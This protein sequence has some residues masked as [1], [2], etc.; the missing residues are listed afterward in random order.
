MADCGNAE[1]SGGAPHTA[2]LLCK[3]FACGEQMQH[4]RKIR[5]R[6]PVRVLLRFS[7][8]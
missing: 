8:P 2:G 4:P 3:D 1:L 7:G 5:D 6:S